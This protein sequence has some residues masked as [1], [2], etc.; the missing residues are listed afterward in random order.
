MWALAGAV[1]AAALG[2]SAAWSAEASDPQAGWRFAFRDFVIAAWAPPPATEADYA[3]VKAAHFN[4]VMSP[5]Y[6]LPQVSL[7]LAQK[8]G[9]EVMVDTYTPNDKAWGGT[10]TAYTPHPFHH[11]ATLPE[12]EWL[13][14]RYGTHPAL[15]GYLLGDD[16]GKLPP[17]LIET[18][19][20]LRRNAPQLF[21][22]ICQNDFRPESLL[23]AGQPLADPQL[24]P[25]LYQRGWPVEQQCE[26]LCD[27]LDKLRRACN[28]HHLIS[29]P[30]FNVTGVESASLIRFQP[31]A[32]L[33]YGAQGIWYFT[34]D[35]LTKREG[36]KPVTLPGYDVV[37]QVNENVERWG[38]ELLGRKCAR[39]LATGLEPEDVLP[40]SD[41]LLVR[42]ADGNLLIGILVKDDADTCAMVVDS[43]TGP[44]ADGQ[45]ERKVRVGFAPAVTAVTVLAAKATRV[46]GSEVALQ[47]PPGGGQLL[48]LHGEGVRELA[49]RL[50]RMP[51]RTPGQPVLGPE[52]L[53]AYWSFDDGQG[54]VARDQSGLGNDLRL[55]KPKWVEG[56]VGGAL[57]LSETA[58]I[59]QCYR[60]RLPEVE[61]MS[62]E[63]WVKPMRYPEHY[64]CVI[65]VGKGGADRLEFG[66]GPDNLY[67]VISNGNEHSGGLLYVGNMKQLI[68]ENGWGH[69]AVVAGPQGAATYINGQKVAATDFA[70]R[71]S[72]WHDRIEL[73]ARGGTEEYEGLVDEVRIWGRVLSEEEIRERAGVR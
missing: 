10:A 40:P 33:A 18:V 52:A 1:A 31:Y 65:F 48:R 47:L 29:W 56:K 54:D 9:L 30:M 43:R 57:D 20:F 55:T 38:P 12:L 15:A 59:G 37:R 51:R 42:A 44:E 25:T 36:G 19:D 6:E 67:P 8:H 66:F 61:A 73:G 21:P 23:E 35:C 13:H 11:P 63:A 72:F 49:D 70:G 46:D 62:I 71:F 53:M 22:W 32:C 26:L 64:G 28:Q 45:G 60:A 5:R 68:S 7:D 39:V 24:Y 14:Q 41:D 27:S 2:C 58:A 69:I 4:L 16:Y 34:Y 50:E 3:L 17:E